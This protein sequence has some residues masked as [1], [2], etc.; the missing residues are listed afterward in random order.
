MGFVN[1]AFVM[2][3]LYNG[4]RVN[5]PKSLKVGGHI[6]EITFPHKFSERSDCFGYFDLARG[7]ILITNIDANGNELTETQI[8]ATFWHEVFHA[9]NTVYCCRKLGKSADEEE[10]TEALAQGMTQLLRDNFK[11]LEIK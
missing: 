8:E 6:L 11:A 9:I 2:S 10:M 3:E 1:M 4:V 5:I 7:K